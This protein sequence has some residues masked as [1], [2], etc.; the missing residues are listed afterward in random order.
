MHKPL[1]RSRWIVELR[2]LTYGTILCGYLVV[3]VEQSVSVHVCLSVCVKLNDCVDI[4]A[5]GSDNGNG[6]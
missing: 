1:A 6:G 3:Q 2:Q 5:Y 4:M